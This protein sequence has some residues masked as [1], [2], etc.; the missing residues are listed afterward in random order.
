MDALVAGAPPAGRR[1]LRRPRRSAG[2]LRSWQRRSRR[3]MPMLVL[4]G[5]GRPWR[6]PGV[7]SRSRDFRDFGRRVGRERRPARKLGRA[8]RRASAAPSLPVSLSLYLSFSLSLSL[9]LFIS[10]RSQTKYFCTLT[11]SENA[12]SR[13]AA[14]IVASWLRGRKAAYRAAPLFAEIAVVVGAFRALS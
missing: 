4:P 13:R 12:R 14:V 10:S 7:G 3:Y 6:S 8:E 11:R 1:R 2:A 5:R 9:S